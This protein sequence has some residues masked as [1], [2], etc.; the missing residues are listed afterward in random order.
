MNQEKTEAVISGNQ[1]SKNIRF[2][3]RCK[4]MQK[5][6]LIYEEDPTDRDKIAVGVSFFPNVD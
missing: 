2:N 5:P 4:D 6:R 1:N 3:F